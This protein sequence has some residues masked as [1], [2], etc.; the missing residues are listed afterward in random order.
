MNFSH[1]VKQ[2]EDEPACTD[3]FVALKRNIG[4]L[5]EEDKAFSATYLIIYK[6]SRSHH[7]LF[8]DQEISPSVSIAA[9]EQMLGYLKLLLTPISNRDL[10]SS[11]ESLSQ[12]SY[13]Y[14][15]TD[16]ILGI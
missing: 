16:K 10:T 8:E 14:F 9:K 11:Y 12:V 15:M 4:K 1:V 6:I 13:D 5:I 7:L 2:F 3:A